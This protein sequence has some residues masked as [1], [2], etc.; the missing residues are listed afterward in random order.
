MKRSVLAGVA[1]V[2]ALIGTLLIAVYAWVNWCGEEKWNL[3]EAR[4]KAKGEPLKLI[5]IESKPVPDAQNIA[6]API[7]AEL[8]AASSAESARLLDV[9]AFRGGSREGASKLVSFARKVDPG[10]ADSESEAASVVLNAAAR[11]SELWEDVR[12]AARRPETV[13]PVNYSDGFTMELPHLTPMLRLGQSLEAQALSH[14]ELGDS[15]A[16]ADDVELL[17]NLAD[18]NQEPVILISHL[19][20]LS[21]LSIAVDVVNAGIVGSAWTDDEL[22]EF[23]SLLGGETILIDLQRT[24]R[25]ERAI[26]LLVMEQIRVG[27]RSY[28]EATGMEASGGGMALEMAWRWLRPVGFDFEDQ[29]LYAELI[30]RLIDGMDSPV[31]WP[32]SEVEMD[33]EVM[34][35]RENGW[36]VFRT[37]MSV[38]TFPSVA[39][40][41]RRAMGLQVRLDLLVVACGIERFRLRE[42]RLPSELREL[43]PRDLP[44][45]PMDLMSGSQLQYGVVDPGNDFLLYS[46]GWNQVDDAGSSEGAQFREFLESDDWRWGAGK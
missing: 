23:Q 16:A 20:R 1:I 22:A 8:F 21:L 29:A 19:V 9:E 35:L 28:R 44:E 12:E 2:A 43:V 36:S 32:K 18:R 7:F 3:V 24:F 10:F 4:L 25:G 5:E 15:A 6:A 34:K 41:I 39:P 40:V 14:L 38:M 26:A 46:V 30:Q 33:A 27:A 11:E 17:V 13:W 42:R 37:P 31:D 45:L